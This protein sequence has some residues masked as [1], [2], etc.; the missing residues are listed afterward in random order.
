MFKMKYF[1]S[2]SLLLFIALGFKVY[3]QYD[4]IQKTHKLIVLNESKSLAN[5]ISAFR[6]TYQKTFISNH[7]EMKSDMIDLLP[8]KTISEISDRFALSTKE[9]ILIRTVSDRPRN[10]KNAANPF[11]MEMMA[12]FRDHPKQ[13]DKF[14]E[15]EGA[16]YYLKPMFIEKSCLK[17]HGK[18]EETIPSIRDKYET[19]YD[20]KVGDLRGL[21]NIK[22]K[23]QG[24]FNALYNNFINTLI[25]TILLYIL[26]LLI[27]YT[28]IKNIRKKEDHY[29][30]KLESDI[31][32][33]TSELQKQK[34]VFE[35]LFE[36]STDGILI[37]DDGKFIQCNEKIA[38][39]LSCQTKDDILHKDINA[40]SPEFQ[41]DGRR[42]KEKAYE[43]LAE[44]M[45][46]DGI[47][48]EWYSQRMNGQYFWSEVSMTTIWLDDHKVLYATIRDISEK[49]MAQKKLQEQK[50]VLYYQAHH[51]ALTGLPN[52]VLFNE[53]LTYGIKKAKKQSTKLALF[54]I[55]LDQFKQINDSLGHEIGDKVLQ[56][57]A[58]RLKAK[59]G[60]RDTLSRLGGDEFIIIMDD[61]KDI[62][63]VSTIAEKILKVLIQPI[64]LKGQTLYTSCSIGISLYPQD[65]LSAENLLKF[66]D[67]AMYN[68]K[69]EGR[70]NYQFYRT[71]MTEYAY[72]RMRMK[73]GLRKALDDNELVVYY[74]PQMDA[75]T[76]TLLGL[77]ALVRWEHPEMGLI[78]PQKF[79]PLAEENG[80]IVEIDR[81]VMKHAMKQLHSWYQEGYAPGV[82]AL[83]ITLTH[84]RREDYVSYLRECI[85]ETYFRT[86]WL[87]LEVTEGEV[88]KKFDEI[89]A[90]LTLLNTLGIGIAIDDF[91]TGHSSLAYLKR[92]PIHKLKID[93]SFIDD[94]PENEEDVAI[95]RAIIALGKSLKLTLLAEGVETEAQKDFLVKNGCQNIQGFY[96]DEALT[97]TQIEQKYLRSDSMFNLDKINK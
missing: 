72:E 55:D 57:V 69:D 65:D 2:F 15:K 33:K 30:H 84:L 71:E 49:K 29:T 97:V 58:E 81:W 74:Q 14:I 66:A 42:S 12:Y 56:V 85:A 6:K 39:I 79:L 76:N 13:V 21:L 78:Y 3:E 43:F 64:H 34:E 73:A 91:G 50:D 54:F 90:K 77:E 51:D 38:K 1:F 28:L 62:Q 68:A 83:N 44:A 31:A 4:H 32:L 24:Y 10:P 93:K 36:K 17:C 9:E 86:E 18:R 16:F 5:F 67:A 19:A 41:P 48:I 35:T 25:L 46:S 87:E 96:Y 20:Y 45:E 27:I 88:M 47:Q 61:C 63:N 23:E 75:S 37:I 59:I 60:K 94:L 95:V 92:L 22:L 89:I 7:I 40:F 11:E 82:L 26:F 70:N 8:V 80:L 53:R 52:R